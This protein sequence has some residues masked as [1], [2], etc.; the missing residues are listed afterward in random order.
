MDKDN[1]HV[2]PTMSE[3]VETIFTS[4]IVELTKKDLNRNIFLGL[5]T[6]FKFRIFSVNK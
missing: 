5:S 4:N 2:I 6:A 1:L 3:K